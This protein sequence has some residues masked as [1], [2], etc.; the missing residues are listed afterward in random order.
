LPYQ[1]EESI[2]AELRALTEKT[3]KLRHELRAMVT[4]GP[5]KDLTRRNLHVQGRAGPEPPAVAPERRQ[6]PRT[7]G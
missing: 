6:K 5:A 2:K 1:D 4:S 3:R 7:K